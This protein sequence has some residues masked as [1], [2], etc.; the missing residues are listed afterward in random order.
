LRDADKQRGAS[1]GRAAAARLEG[2]VGELQGVAGVEVDIRKD[3]SP[4]IRVWLDGSTSSERVGDEIQRVLAAIDWVAEPKPAEP[5]RRSGLGR[6]LNELLE[7]N[8]GSD[9]LPL[10]SPAPVAPAGASRSLLLV[11]VEETAAGVSV[12]VADSE[13]GI[14][15]SPVEDPDSLNQA[16]TAA[17]VQ[18][19]QRRP[20]PRLEAVEVREIAGESV[21]TA[22]LRCDDGS[23]LVG[24]EVIRGGLPYT[25]GQAVWKALT[26]AG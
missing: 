11:A 19:H 24:S 5:V 1:G 13:S 18:L 2:L 23:A 6:G 16:V 9:P 12:R 14:A 8:G 26:F 7:V 3:G 22:L 15:F 4:H 25:L 20:M 21:L 10:R 17:V